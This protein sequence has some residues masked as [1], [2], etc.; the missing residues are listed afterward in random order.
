M[1]PLFGFLKSVLLALL[2]C[3]PIGKAQDPHYRFAHYG[4]EDGLSQSRILAIVQDREGFVWFGTGEGL[5]RFDG[6]DFKVFQN[7]PDD[8]TSLPH[9]MINDL[10]LDRQGHLWVGSLWGLSR[11]EPRSETFENYVIGGQRASVT[12]IVEDGDRLWLGTSQGLFSFEDGVSTAHQKVPGSD[13]YIRELHQARDGQ[14]YFRDSL[15]YF[16]VYDPE[17]ETLAELD[18]AL[19]GPITS[20]YWR[21]DGGL[22]VGSLGSLWFYPDGFESEPRQVLLDGFKNSMVESLLEDNSGNLWIGTQA[23]LGQ[24]SLDNWQLRYMTEDNQLPDGLKSFHINTL[25][26]DQ[27]DNLWVG[28][29]SGGL[30]HLPLSNVRFGHVGGGPYIK[31]GLSTTNVYAITMDR[32]GTLWVGN[33]RG[34]DYCRK[35]ARGFSRV[36]SDEL[37]QGAR[38]LHESKDGVLYA[39][40]AANVPLQIVDKQSLE[41]TPIGPAM[42]MLSIHEAEDGT[43]W[44]GCREGLLELDPS[45]PEKAT[46]HRMGLG[47]LSN[48]VLVTVPAKQEGLW[49]GTMKGVSRFIDGRTADYLQS[50]GIQVI[51]MLPEG[52]DFWLGTSSGLL[53]WKPGSEEARAWDE[54]GKLS[55]DYIYSLLKDDAGFLWIGHGKGL[56]RLDP[57]SGAMHTFDRDHGLQSNEFNHNAKARLHGG[58]LAFGGV[59][60]LNIFRPEDVVKPEPPVKARLT[61]FLLMNKLVKPGTADTPLPVALGYLETMTLAYDDNLFSFEFAAPGSSHPNALRF[62]YQLSGFHDGWVDTSNQRRVLPMTGLAP[63]S[64]TLNIRA[65]CGDEVW[66]P[67]SSLKI[68]VQPPLWRRWQAYLAYTLIIVGLIVLGVRYQ[69]RKLRVEKERIAAFNREL[70]EK[71]VARTALLEERSA[72]LDAQNRDLH[73]YAVELEILDHIVKAINQEMDFA[74]VFHSFMKEGR[75]LFPHVVGGGFLLFRARSS[76]ILYRVSEGLLVRGF[77]EA[78]YAY[79]IFEAIG[80]TE[81]IAEYIAKTIAVDEQGYHTITMEVLSN[82]GYRALLLVQI[83][84]AGLELLN[85]KTLERFREHLVTAVNKARALYELGATQRELMEEAHLAGMAEIATDVIHNIGNAL[86]SVHTSSQILRDDCCNTKVVEML[87][88]LSDKLAEHQEDLP[89][90]L[91]EDPVGR[92]L[93]EALKRIHT[94]LSKNDSAQQR[95]TACLD[96]TLKKAIGLLG[97][98]QAHANNQQQLLT[99]LNLNELINEA[100]L[101][102]SFILKQRGILVRRHQDTLPQLRLDRGKV[103][104]IMLYLLK[105]AWEALEHTSEGSRFIDISTE[106]KGKHVVLKIADFGIGAENDVIEHAFKQGYSTKRDHRGFGLHYCANAVREMHGSI[107]MHSHGR[108]R[109]CRIE[110]RFPISNE[111]IC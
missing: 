51:D 8:P 111:T 10:L 9:G 63:S 55:N 21:E 11:Y 86:N 108:D 101:S 50:Y 91:K 76:R 68:V 44:G 90:F 43:L 66:G 72:L 49:L 83:E 110:I 107:A 39:A 6:F 64:Y 67:I 58:R 18:L 22:W 109:G 85:A 27:T 41:L 42:R 19:G 96:K 95:E 47:Q 29:F 1:K 30:Y 65:A 23:G 88:A 52:D 32:E 5:C 25:Y 46:I 3:C 82:E 99:P 54:G 53:R 97:E 62:Q 20:T 57:N 69:T 59:K 102:K 35:G 13:Q 77:D 33:N 104:R 37:K 75:E 98:S 26:L 103:Q 61:N 84:V 70:E 106:V 31:G 79:E 81:P 15:R 38:V 92:R 24:M 2:F 89:R 16:W 4:L 78:N 100:L 45:A 36:P 28:T 48:M 71:V 40:F 93:P 12:A 60:G 7:E 94:K 105:N 74:G 73:N 34:I 87:G 14:L 17:N 56:T 80:E